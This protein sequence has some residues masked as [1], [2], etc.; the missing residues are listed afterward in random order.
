M[1]GHHY[2]SINDRFSG[3]LNIYHSPPHKTIA[4]TLI[5]TCRAMF[6]S[7]G[8]PEELSTEGG[9][10]FMSTA[11]QNCLTK[12]GVTHGLSSVA[13]PQS[14][15]RAELGVKTAKRIINNV[16][17]QGGIDNDQV[18]KALLQ[19]KNTPLPHIKLSPAQIL[20]HRNL[21]NHISRNEKH[22]HLH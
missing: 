15:G 10:Q 20:L 2:L 21:C 19:N 12:W 7:Y 18:V 11:F 3:W 14:N 5:S 4:D 16:S 6:I 1:S 13:H 22:Y 9:P 17:H 8:I